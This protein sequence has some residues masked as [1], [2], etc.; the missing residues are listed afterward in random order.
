MNTHSG[1]QRKYIALRIV[2]VTLCASNGKEVKTHALLDEGST[3]SILDQGIADEL[4][5]T[6]L[7]DPLRL[8]WKGNQQ[9]SDSDSRRVSLSICGRGGDFRQMENVCTMA[10]FTLPRHSIDSRKMLRS[11]AHLEGIDAP[12]LPDVTP[13][14]LI[15]QEHYH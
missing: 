13:R 9:Q 8:S 6:G 3:V 11:W 14:L 2:P 15:G 10:N 4:G 7:T 5:A 1:I 12:S